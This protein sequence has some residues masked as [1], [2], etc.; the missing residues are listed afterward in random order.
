MVDADGATD[1]P[2]IEK[3]EKALDEIAEDHV[4]WILH[5]LKWGIYFKCRHVLACFRKL[6]P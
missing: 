2:D 1:I 6:L 5:T 4:S 3:L